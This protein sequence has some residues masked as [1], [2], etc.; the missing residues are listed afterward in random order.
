[1][2]VGHGGGMRECVPPFPGESAAILPPSSLECHCVCL[3]RLSS[4][5]DLVKAACSETVNVAGPLVKCPAMLSLLRVSSRLVSAC[6]LWGR[7]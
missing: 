3:V 7:L 6:S 2:A 4:G 5:Q 1:M